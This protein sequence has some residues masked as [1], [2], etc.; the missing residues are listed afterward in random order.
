MNSPRHYTQT[1]NYASYMKSLSWLVFPISDY[2]LYVKKLSLLPFKIAKLPRAPL[3]FD[4]SL[5]TALCAENRVSLLKIEPDRLLPNDQKAEQF[6]KS[7]GFRR[8]RSPI[9]QTKTVLIDLQLS[10]SELL[11]SLRS[12]TRH[13]LR[14]SWQENFRLEIIENHGDEKDYE[15]VETFYSLFEKCAKERH[16]Y[17][18]FRKQTLALWQSFPMKSA[19]FLVS[20]K[21]KTLYSGAFILV[22]DNIAYYKFGASIPAGR[23]KFSSYFL[24]WEMFRWAREKNLQIFD[25]EGTYDPRYKRTQKYAG[26]TQFKKGWSQNEITYLGSFTKLIL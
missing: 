3:D 13:H 5:L 10:E 11:K 14:K 23:E 1:A 26:I 22:H 6:L 12:E 20:A 8:D 17:S 21:D 2:F 24:F 16:F 18:P 25:L 7:Q 15:K 19:L 4:Y 9:L